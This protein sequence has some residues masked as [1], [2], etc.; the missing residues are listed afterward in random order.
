MLTA[1]AAQAKDLGL[2]ITKKW[3]GFIPR[4][5]AKLRVEMGIPGFATGLHI[6]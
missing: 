1:L 6:Q 2:D 5:P 4:P 3:C